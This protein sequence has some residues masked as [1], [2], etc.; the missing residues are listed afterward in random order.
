MR[1]ALI[2]LLS[3]LALGVAA[4]PTAFGAHA[5]DAGV[6]AKWLGPDSPKCA[7]VSDIKSVSDVVALTPEQFQFAR[8]LYV[9]TPPVSRALPPGDHA[10]LARSGNSALI[11]LVSGDT[12]CARFLAPDFV[13]TMLMQVGEGES[14]VVG[15]QM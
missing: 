10:V 13:Q 2:V 6:F 15:E 1:R 5:Q 3:T 12:F 9:A 4:I 7:P 8:A 11:A 14:G